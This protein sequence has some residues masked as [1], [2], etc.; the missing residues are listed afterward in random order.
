MRK[1]SGTTTFESDFSSA[2]SRGGGEQKR[3]D[4][5]KSASRGATGTGTTGTGSSGAPQTTQVDTFRRPSRESRSR[6]S[7]PLMKEKDPRAKRAAKEASS[8][9]YY[10]ANQE[11][12]HS[13]QFLNSSVSSD[14]LEDTERAGAY[15]GD[16]S[17]IASR[18]VIDLPLVV[19][20]EPQHQGLAMGSSVD[21]IA[22]SEGG[23]GNKTPEED[24]RAPQP[25]QLRSNRTSSASPQVLRAATIVF[26]DKNNWQLHDDHEY[27][28]GQKD[29]F[30][31]LL[32]DGLD[33]AGWSPP[34]RPE[35]TPIASNNSRRG[36]STS[37]TFPSSTSSP[38]ATGSAQ[39]VVVGE[40]A[41]AS[42]SRTAE[43]TKTSSR[44][45][46]LGRSTVPVAYVEGQETKEPTGV[47]AL[48]SNT[49]NAPRPGEKAS[50]RSMKKPDRRRR[51]GTGRTSSGDAKRYF[52]DPTGSTPTPKRRIILEG[53][54]D[55]DSSS[56]SSFSGEMRSS[57]DDDRGGPGEATRQETTAL[58][59]ESSSS[60]GSAMKT[61]TASVIDS[62]TPN[63]ATSNRSFATSAGAAPAATVPSIP[64][65]QYEGGHAQEATFSSASNNT[66]CDPLSSESD[67]NPTRT[68]KSTEGAQALPSPFRP[69]RR[70]KPGPPPKTVLAELAEALAWR[71]PSPTAGAVVAAA[72][73]PSSRTAPAPA[74]VRIDRRFEGGPERENIADAVKELADSP[75]SST[76]TTKGVGL[77]YPESVSLSSPRSS[78]R[79]AAASEVEPTLTSI[80]IRVGDAGVIGTMVKRRA[81]EIEDELRQRKSNSVVDSRATRAS[82]PPQAFST[83]AGGSDGGP[84]VKVPVTEDT[85]LSVS[86]AALR[87]KLKRPP[88]FLADRRASTWKKCFPQDKKKSVSFAPTTTGAASPCPT[89]SGGGVSASSANAKTS[90]T[91]LLCST[92]K[93]G[94][95]YLHLDR[96]G[97]AAS[98]SVPRSCSQ[99][100]SC[101]SRLVSS[102]SSGGRIFSARDDKNEKQ[103]RTT[104]TNQSRTEALMMGPGVVPESAPK[105]ISAE[106]DRKC[107]EARSTGGAAPV[108]SLSSTSSV[109]LPLSVQMIERL[110]LQIRSEQPV[111]SAL[112][113]SMKVLVREADS[114]TNT[115]DGEDEE[116]PCSR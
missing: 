72:P 69:Q 73:P 14:F 80:G 42:S 90:S 23:A 61:T 112:D 99:A 48:A 58:V 12:T 88:I 11:G 6:F 54:H 64:P 92:R 18:D 15:H 17:F 114:A 68:S 100:S 97:A 49:L 24:A 25:L 101:R 8:S 36:P 83:S 19:N 26:G 66:G 57:A 22:S 31:D 76:I 78:E 115:I 1:R 32:A 93:A 2:T 84:P 44:S 5:S 111:T 29:D 16:S 28:D 40:Q 65:R 86:P 106:I 94:S 20:K 102:T 38:S 60:T 98:W 108:W 107:G 50:N 53:H 96:A 45:L 59:V 81:A 34:A 30:D 74:P 21:A 87:S 75:P 63:S 113:A 41:L 7:Q 79:S 105:W 103:R 4:Q 9:N 77:F 70:S 104:S 56:S 55:E 116:E 67:S 39:S 3:K 13:F 46:K 52:A 43:K 85:T 51:L 110:G 89:K 109:F 10:L 95:S 35:S 33:D 37:N 62:A 71:G 27:H 47:V 91:S 82:G